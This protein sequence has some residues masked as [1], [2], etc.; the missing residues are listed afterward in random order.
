MVFARA[1]FGLNR[2]LA[3]STESLICGIDQNSPGVTIE[4]CSIGGL[5]ASRSS[6]VTN[7]SWRSIGRSAFLKGV[8]RTVKSDPPDRTEK[9]E[10]VS[11]LRFSIVPWQSTQVISIALRVSPYSFP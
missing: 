10:V 6:R 8:A 1:A 2:G 3:G 11:V 9:P 5:F 4:Y 7:W